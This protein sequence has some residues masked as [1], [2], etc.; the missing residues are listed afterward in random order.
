MV[1]TAN[2]R[3]YRISDPEVGSHTR[4]A[5]ATHRL[6]RSRHIV[7]MSLMIQ[8]TPAEIDPIK[9]EVIFEEKLVDEARMPENHFQNGELDRCVVDVELDYHKVVFFDILK[10]MRLEFGRVDPFVVKF[11]RRA[12]CGGD[13]AVPVLLEL[14][15]PGNDLAESDATFS[16]HAFEDR[17]R[18]TN[19]VKRTTPHVEEDCPL[20]RRSRTVSFDLQIMEVI[21]LDCLVPE[22]IWAIAYL[23]KGV[24][25]HAAERFDG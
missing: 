21:Y 19:S 16:V 2:A 18:R 9:I 7:H 4:F 8:I 15:F 14:R 24:A 3:E 11:D 10:K 12:L 25:S 17:N 20:W 13:C 22:I 6:Q 1:I 5:E 23:C